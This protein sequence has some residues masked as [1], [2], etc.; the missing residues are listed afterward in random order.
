M[1]NLEL[2]VSFYSK[3]K[4]MNAKTDILIIDTYGDSLKFYNISDYVFVG[5]SLN[6]DLI[7]NS[8]QNPI[9]PA[10]LGCKIFHGPNIKNFTEIYNYLENLNVTKKIKN[11]EELSVSMVEEFKKNKGKD[12]EIGVKIRDHGENIFNSVIMELKKYI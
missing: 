8:G 6:D 3:I 5:K 9:E 10:R 12:V 11:S 4:D 1:S 2:E 7:T